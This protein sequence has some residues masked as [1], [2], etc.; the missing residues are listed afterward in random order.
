[1]TRRTASAADAA[2]DAETL[3]RPLAGAR[4][5]VLAVSGGPDSTALMLL[6]AGWSGRPPSLVVTVDHGLRPESA[7]EARSV[8]ENAT[9]LGLPHRIMT[10][11]PRPAS[12]NLQDWARR[13]RYACLVAAAREAGF[14]T[15]ATAHHRDDQAETFLLRLA[16]GSGVYGLAA[17]AEQSEIDGLRLVRPLLGVPRKTLAEAAAASGLVIAD[18]PGNRDQRFD[19]VRLRAIMPLLAEH[20]LT[21]ERLAATAA[22]LGRA[23]AALDGCAMALLRK[24]FCADAFGT[25]DGM[26]GALMDAPPEI[27][28][29]ALALMLQA[30]GGAD[31]TPRLDRLE[32]LSEAI[33]DAG[34]GGRL[35]RTLHGVVASVAK[36]RLTMRREWG[37]GGPMGM[38]A[39]P[40]ATIVWDRRFRVHVPERPGRL[41]VGPLGRSERRLGAAHAGR[42]ELG[43]LPGLY[44]DSMLVAAPESVTAID[45]GPPLSA[46]CTE[47]LVGPQLGLAVR[48]AAPH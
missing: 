8:A 12:G 33:R 28:S 46:L 41:T 42:A 4:G 29:R 35:Q 20:G 38:A 10:A 26:A 44:A 5:V 18:D 27:G 47:C 30:V 45:D 37:R 17:M 31:Y 11:P 40:G 13:A 19:R 25:V 34:A 15:I 7:G 21:A 23:A 48:V 6:Y 32:A 24:N 3:F 1:M 36:G 2:L 22:R 16:R 39:P 9:K 43:V 14:D